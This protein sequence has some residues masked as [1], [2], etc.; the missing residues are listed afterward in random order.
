MSA[1]VLIEGMD[2]EDVDIYRRI[3][4]MEHSVIMKDVETFV[5]FEGASDIQKVSRLQHI[6][7]FYILD[8]RDPELISDISRIIDIVSIK[9][10]KSKN[11]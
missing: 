3:I 7:D 11:I 9:N 8:E 5:R 1:N 10:L 4:D 2:P 6:M